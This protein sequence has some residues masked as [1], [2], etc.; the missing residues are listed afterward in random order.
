MI[1]EANNDIY[2]S[3]I[4][5]IAKY[6]PKNKCLIIRSNIDTQKTLKKKD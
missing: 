4:M 2:G 5:F 3:K 6:M 1:F